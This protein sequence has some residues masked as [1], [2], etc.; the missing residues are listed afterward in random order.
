VDTP[1]HAD[2]GSEVERI[3][4]MVDGVL[5]LVDA[6]DGPMPQTRFVLKK[7]LDLDLAPIVV[8]NKVDRPGAKPHEALDK[9][10]QLFMDLGAH[11]HQL[12]FHAV[13]ASGREG[14]AS[15]EAEEKTSDLT[16]LF[17]T[18]V[19]YVPGPVCDIK[20]PFQMLVT[21]INHDNFVGRISIGRIFNG[22][23]K[24]N[25]PVTLI[26]RDGTKINARVT[27]LLRFAGLQQHEIN[28]VQAGDIAAMA[29]IEGTNV[30]DTI[31]SGEDPKPL[32]NL[33]IDEPTMA[34]EFS[35]ND[36]PFAGQ[37]GEFL[38]TRHVR[39]RLMHEK[40][41]GVG[42]EVRENESASTFR[43]SG[44]GELHLSILIENMR[45]D[46]FELSVSKPEVLNK[47]VHGKIM[48]PA[49]YL[50]VDV[51]QEYQGAILENLGARGANMKN[52]HSDGNR[53]RLE[54][55]ITARALLGFKSELLTLTRGTGMMHHSYHGYI[56]KTGQ[57]N[58]RNRGVLIALE[59]GNTTAYALDNLQTRGT[60]F[61]GPDTQ[62]Y[63]GMIIGESVR[64]A[65]MVVNPCKKKALTNMRAS[66]SD[67][68]P[69]LAPP[70][71]L[72]LEQ[73]LEF[74]E[75]D[76]LVEVTPKNLRLRKKIL[77]H[78]ARKRSEKNP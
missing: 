66:G 1:G 33:H 43:V 47:K 42:L 73:S 76:E 45:R 16:Y 37:D 27:K 55:L 68:A 30:G 71:I 72:S 22:Q 34:M 25:E 13:Y 65:S 28:G 3:L 8:I 77:D 49:E 26:K 6:F 11:D 14:W 54:Y 64:D 44:R 31:A 36:S 57:E 20:K 32:A 9:T 78:T 4:T 19:K 63:R 38:T 29:G 58:K 24:K 35:V 74:I 46:G 62:V 18:I 39:D 56:P 15:Q 70:N 59:K 75:T 12:D 67:D 10:F 51:D 69:I 60:L 40:E 50:I 48:E 5:L 41:I 61:V 21:M 17:D 7:S 2:F 53:V 23:I 52:M